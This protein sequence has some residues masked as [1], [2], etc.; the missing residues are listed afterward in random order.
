VNLDRDGDSMIATVCDHGIGIPEVDQPFIFK[1]FHRGRNVS[2]RAGT[3]LGLMIVKR[4]VELHD[5]T[6]EFKAPSGAVRLLSSTSR[7][8]VP[9]EVKIKK[10][11]HEKNSR[12]RR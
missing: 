3:G 5:G 1:A 2:N 9:L 12:H 11:L 8:S 7:C 10:G 4:C 6:I